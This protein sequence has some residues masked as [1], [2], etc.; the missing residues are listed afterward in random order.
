MNVV[1]KGDQPFAN[2]FILPKFAQLFLSLGR[3]GE[4]ICRDKESMRR[5]SVRRESMRRESARRESMRREPAERNSVR[6]CKVMQ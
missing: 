5:E 1:N 4:G 6:A 2:G 3:C